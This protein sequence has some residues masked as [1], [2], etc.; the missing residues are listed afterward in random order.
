VSSPSVTPGTG[1]GV[2]HNREIGAGR[3]TFVHHTN[4]PRRFGNGSTYSQMTQMS[5]TIIVAIELSM[6]YAKLRMNMR[7]G[8]IR[9]SCIMWVIFDH[10]RPPGHIMPDHAGDRGAVLPGPGA[11]RSPPYQTEADVG[12]R[13]GRHADH[14][15]RWPWTQSSR[16]SACRPSG[17]L[18][19]G[20][21]GTGPV[22]ESEAGLRP[23]GRIANNATLGLH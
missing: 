7:L 18:F 8:N 3:T 19:A 13:P 2:A 15:V 22:T 6:E 20:E 9:Y 5:S 23:C 14:L 1:L 12:R 11:S 17:L 16:R 4:Q 10:L 21:P